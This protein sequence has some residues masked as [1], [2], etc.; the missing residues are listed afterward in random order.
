MNLHTIISNPTG[1]ETK[2]RFGKV[3]CTSATVAGEEPLAQ[4]RH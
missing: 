3:P 2:G 4:V 1:F